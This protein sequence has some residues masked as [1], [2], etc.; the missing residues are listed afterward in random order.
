MKKIAITNQK[1][2]VG[3]TTTA[4]NIAS[5]LAS[6]GKKVLLIDIDPQAHATN[7]LGLPEDMDNTI[8]HLF[9]GEKELNDCIHEIG[10]L[11]LLP[12]CLDL[13]SLEL[14]LVNELARESFLKSHLEGIEYDY[15]IVDTNPSLGM[16]TI[17]SLV[18]ADEI[19]VPIQP[20]YFSMR[21]LSLLAKTFNDIKKKLNPDLALP[22]I[23][24]TMYLKNILADDVIEDVRS[25]AKDKMFKTKIR[26]NVKLA[27]AP[28][29]GKSIFDYSPS[30][31]GAKD[32]RALVKEIIKNGV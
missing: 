21:G 6:R 24:V 16:L 26:R 15:V 17:N 32:Y 29:E 8:Y 11:H 22:Y 20:E 19:I 27:E 25:F 14:E 7:H 10:R 13:A 3:K 12:S 2:G 5:G 30:C 31:N 4:V 1:G 9:R 23:L 28:N 18:F